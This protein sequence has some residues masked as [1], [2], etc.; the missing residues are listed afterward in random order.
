MQMPIM[1]QTTIKEN[2][3]SFPN[4]K[5]SIIVPVYNVASYLGNC[6]ESILNQTFED[7]EL[8]LVDDGS[9]DTSAQRCDLYGRKDP[10]IHVFHK[11]NGGLSSARNYG[12]EQAKGDLIGFVDGDDWIESDFYEKLIDQM[13]RFN[14]D[15]SACRFVKEDK[16]PE[17]GAITAWE[18]SVIYTPEEA[19]AQ[20]FLKTGTRYSACD[21]LY[22]R[23]LF[24]AIRYPEGKVYE[25]KATTY[26]LFHAS[27]RIVYSPSAK[28]HYLIR[29]DSL[30]RQ[31]PQKP[32]Y[33]L[34][35][36][37]DT[38]IAF[39]ETHYPKLVK[40]AEASYVEEC[41]ILLQHMVAQ[42]HKDK[43]MQAKCEAVLLRLQEK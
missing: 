20:M 9:T 13:V 42:G 43:V 41:E 3:P 22:A 1:N 31:A 21:K 34:F 23:K 30:M 16:H 37:N 18:P 33:D 7:F 26:L 32:N 6:I 11:A 38:L 40:T 35:E 27:E 12:L 17:L 24:D 10:R 14:A 2:V 15:I 5:L 39:L 36:V 4:P 28:Y 25:D 8:L 29:P 19:L